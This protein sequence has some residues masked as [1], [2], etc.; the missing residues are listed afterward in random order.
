[1]PY[2]ANRRDFNLN[3]IRMNA[4]RRLRNGTSRGAN[5]DIN[6]VLVGLASICDQHEN[7]HADRLHSTRYVMSF[8]EGQNQ[9]NLKLRVA[10]MY[11]SICFALGYVGC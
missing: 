5:F 8:A 9:P 1:M 10:I 2:G 11:V 6:A 4:T 7:L 3:Y